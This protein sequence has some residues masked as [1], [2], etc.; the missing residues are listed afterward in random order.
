MKLYTKWGITF[1]E[2]YTL[3][4]KSAR[5]MKYVSEKDIA[6]AILQKQQPKA[7]PKRKPIPFVPDPREAE[8]L[9]TQ[10]AEQGN[11]Y[12]AY[13]LGKMYLN[14]DGAV[15]K[16]PDKAAQWFQQAAEQNNPYAQYQLGKLHLTGGESKQPS[17]KPSLKKQSD[18]PLRVD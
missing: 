8:K 10:S 15:E 17:N 4:D 7:A 18:N 16:D 2:P 14:G 3:Q 13:Q 11:E 12:A 9:F 5:P 6:T 1:G